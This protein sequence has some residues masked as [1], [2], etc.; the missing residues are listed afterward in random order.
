MRHF[1]REFANTML[2]QLIVTG[3]DFSTNESPP[4]QQTA[5]SCAK[6]YGEEERSKKIIFSP[7]P[8]QSELCSISFWNTLEIYLKKTADIGSEGDKNGDDEK[9][10]NVNTKRTF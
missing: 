2:D 6:K 4:W 7:P 9:T 3:S 10:K 5:A 1:P 8:F